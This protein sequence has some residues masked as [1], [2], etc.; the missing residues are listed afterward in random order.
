MVLRVDTRKIVASKYL[1]TEKKRKG[2]KEGE[3]EKEGTI[4]FACVSK[5]VTIMIILVGLKIMRL[6][7]K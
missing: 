6:G 2:M 1:E 3:L 5:L 4:Y 7:A